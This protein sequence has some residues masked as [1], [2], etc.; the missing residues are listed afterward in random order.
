MHRLWY[1]LI[2]FVS[3]ILQQLFLVPLGKFLWGEPLLPIIVLVILATAMGSVMAEGF[4]FFVGFIWGFV[5]IDTGLP[6]GIYPLLL[7]IIA[8]TLGR[9]LYDR[10]RAP[11]TL[12]LVICTAIVVPLW[13]LGNI[14]LKVVFV[15]AYLPS[16][17]EFIHVFLSAV[18][19]AL[20]C[21]LV[22]PLL[23]RLLSR[24][25]WNGSV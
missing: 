11:G 13:G 4:G 22:T 23:R 16:L 6:Q 14:A 15:S 3:V 10:F 9:L 25:E 17:L 12:L 24:W 8:F 1:F 19:S 21:F 18:Y 2:L 7:T 5:K 20:L